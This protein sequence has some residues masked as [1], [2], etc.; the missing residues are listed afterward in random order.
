MQVA[1]CLFEKLRVVIALDNAIRK[2]VL[3]IF[4]TTAARTSSIK[5][6]TLQ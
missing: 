6:V 2:K 5:S 3:A 4:G 1:I